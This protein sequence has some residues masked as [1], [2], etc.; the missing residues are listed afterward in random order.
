M[1][2]NLLRKLCDDDHWPFIQWE[3]EVGRGKD[4]LLKLKTDDIIC[5][6]IFSV[7]PKLKWKFGE[8]AEQEMNE[9]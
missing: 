4:E 5:K 2:L 6:R 7:G 1:K 8:G 9:F 3:W